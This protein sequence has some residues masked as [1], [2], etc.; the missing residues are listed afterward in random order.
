[1]SG[2]DTTK[3][4]GGTSAGRTGTD[5]PRRGRADK[6]AA[7]LHAACVVFGRDG[8]SRAAV[9]TIA[10]EASTSTRTIYN[11][12][13][14]GKEELFRSVMEWSSA[15]VRDEQLARLRRYLDPQRPPHPRDLERDLLAL[16]RAWSDLM[17]DFRDHFLLVRHILVEAGHLP[18]DTVQA[19]QEAGPRAV[20]REF[21]SALAALSD[22][23]LIDAHGDLDQV[24]THFMALISPNAVQHSYWGVT[25]LPAEEIDR[26]IAS[27]VRAFLRAYGGAAT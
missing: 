9:D 1:M 17:A 20:R 14:G 6:A 24:A 5:Q 23:G 22:H 16:A 12:F 21:A 8:Y 26:L 2:T 10:T 4:T 25:P 15:R 18:A 19:W 27:G 13:P 11:Y 7:I 3:S